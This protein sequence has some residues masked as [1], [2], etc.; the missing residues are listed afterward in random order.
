MPDDERAKRLARMLQ[1]LEDLTRQLGASRPE[2][3]G[4]ADDLLTELDGLTGVTPDTL[5]PRAA[6]VVDAI[7]E[8]ARALSIVGDQ[9]QQQAAVDRAKGLER[10]GISGLSAKDVLILVLVALLLLR[11]GE[12]HPTAL[13]EAI[14]S[15]NLQMAAIIIALAAYLKKGE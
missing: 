2:F 15:N 7:D 10:A 8:L 3:K 11:S 13:G 9:P 6:G 14:E 4:L 12:V 5:T 1:E